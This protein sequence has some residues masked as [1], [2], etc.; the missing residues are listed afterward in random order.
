MDYLSRFSKGRILIAPGIYDPLSAIIAD[1]MGFDFLYLSGA[2]ISYSYLGLPDMSFTG[3][4]EVESA[5][6]RI[7][8]RVQTPII[9][10]A[11]NG[12]GNEINVEHT[13][14]LLE[15]SGA[16]AIQIEDQKTPKRCGHLNGK[17]VLPEQEMVFKIKAALEARKS[18][19]IIARTDALSVNGLNDAIQRGNLYAES[20]ADIVFIEAP[21]SKQDLIDIGKKV[22]GLKMVN[23][24]EGGKTPLFD[25]EELQKMGF[26]LVIY[27]G[28]AIRTISHSL[29]IL[30]KEIKEKGTT[31]NFLGN[32]LNFSQL[33]SL[34]DINKITGK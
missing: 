18:A 31:K 15:R 26:N 13:V 4:S 27:P 25:S 32:M 7:S 6:R 14:R 11:D 28:A 19:L 29:E 10:D 24:V 23:M 5:I 30:Y 34:L 16:T 21:S 33:Q 22:K 20:G 8:Y 17:E 12:Y 3:L 1:K 2:S 9:C